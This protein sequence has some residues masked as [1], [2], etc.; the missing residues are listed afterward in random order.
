MKT[1][2]SVL[3]CVAAAAI[4]ATNAKALSVRASARRSMAKLRWSGLA[5]A[6]SGMLINTFAIPV[7]NYKIKKL[8]WN[9]CVRFYLTNKVNGSQD[10]AES[11][12]LKLFN[13]T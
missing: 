2:A 9:R 10:E 7:V 3:L 8:S 11:V 12:H 1:F 4:A 13:Q 6:Q 5:S